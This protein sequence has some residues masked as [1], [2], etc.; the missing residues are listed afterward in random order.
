[1]PGVHIVTD[2]SC[3]LPEE[4]VDDLDVTVVPLTIRFGSD[5][6][7]D[8]TELSATDFYKKMAA[9]DRLP[10][11]AA[12]SPGAFETAFRAAAEAGAAGVVCINLS[13]SLS[14]TMAAA[15][16][17]SQSV[18]ESI[19]VRIV[20]SRSVT[21]GLGNQ[22]T[23]AAEAARD[24]AS[25]DDVEAL[26]HDLVPRTRAFGALD[27]LEN[28]R[29]GGRI[30]G[31]QALLG[32]MLAI[33]PLV[34]VSSGEVEEAGK[35]RTR[36]RALRWLRERL[37]QEPTVERLAVVHAA[38]ADIDEFVDSLAPRYPRDEIH[39]GV[40]GPVIG[41]HAGPGVVGVIWQQPH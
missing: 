38:A 3:D 40:I 14:A 30:G 23:A 6:F 1:M 34:D 18:R 29:K 5:E 20:D 36:A 16:N 19:D 26:V 9:S 32:Q 35:Q 25:L 39:V 13:S 41:T 37:F 21:L 33:K 27:T 15:Q 17:A 8:R 7:V 28:L 2:S 22:V 24:G 11:T 31:A 12:P 10:E 4:V